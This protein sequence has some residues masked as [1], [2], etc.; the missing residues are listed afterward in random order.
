MFPVHDHSSCLQL[1]FTTYLYTYAGRS[2]GVDE[3]VRRKVQEQ[4]K[5]AF[6]ELFDKAEEH[7]LNILLEPWVLLVSNDQESFQKVILGHRQPIELQI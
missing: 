4:L 6:E 5:P 2:I 7:T 3:E 1:L